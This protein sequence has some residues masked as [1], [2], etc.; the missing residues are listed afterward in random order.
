MSH[1]FKV[2]S[3]VIPPFLQI[4]LSRHGYF[5]FAFLDSVL[6]LIATPSSVARDIFKS[7]F[8]L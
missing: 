6:N 1:F 3:A 5:I 4:S 7:F 8:L 2:G